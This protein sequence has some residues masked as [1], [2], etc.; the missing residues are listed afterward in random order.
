M[1]LGG[2]RR[3]VPLKLAYK[4]KKTAVSKTKYSMLITVR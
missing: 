4:T 3:W 1:Y 2:N